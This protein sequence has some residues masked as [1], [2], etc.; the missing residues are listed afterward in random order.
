MKHPLFVGNKQIGPWLYRIAIGCAP[1]TMQLVEGEIQLGRKVTYTRYDMGPDPK[2]C[3]N[4]VPLSFLAVEVTLAD[5]TK[6]YI[7]PDEL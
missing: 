1:D 5:G 4:N 3:K 7:H 2:D 6:G